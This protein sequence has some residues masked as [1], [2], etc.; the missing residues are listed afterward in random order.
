MQWN[1]MKPTNIKKGLLSFLLVIISSL[2]SFAQQTLWVGQSYTFDV[3][4]SVMGITANMSWSTSGGYLSLSGSG[5]YRNITVTQY[6][7]GTATVT[8]EWDYKLTSSG[9]YT[10]TK[11]QVTISCRDNQVSISPTS[12]TMS[13]GETRYVSYRHQYDNQYTSSANAYYQ[14]SDPSICTVSS[15]GE[16]IAKS[17][18][19]T[20]IN[21][22]SKISSVSPYCKVTVEN[23]KPTSISIPA[24]MTMTAGEQRTL[25]AN[26]I[27]SNAQTT[28]SWK[29]SNNDVATVNNSGTVIAKKHGYVQIAATT[30]N[31]L[32]STCGVT[33]NK[34]KLSLTSS[35]GSG[36]IQNNTAI[37]LLASE[38]NANIYYTIDGSMPT[39]SSTLYQTPILLSGN[40]KVKAFATHQDFVD[41]DVLELEFSI[42]SLSLVSTNPLQG[43]KD[44]SP[45]IIPCFNFSSSIKKGSSFDNIILS[46]EGETISHEAIIEGN[47]LFII[48]S[49]SLEHNSFVVEI[50][51]NAISTYSDESNTIITSFFDYA[52]NT[53]NLVDSWTSRSRLMD[54]GDLYIWG[55][56]ED[57]PNTSYGITSYQGIPI[58]VLS[59]IKKY[60]DS[61]YYITKDGILMGWGYNYNDYLASNPDNSILGDGTKIHRDNAVKISDNVERIETGWTSGLIKNDGTLW[62]WGQNRF[63][64]IGQGNSGTTNYALSPVKVL[65][66]VKDF[67]LGTWHSLALKNDGSVWAW[68]YNKAIGKSSS[69]YSPLKIIDS[70]VVEIMA[71]SCHNIVRKSNGDVYCFGENSYGEIGN[72]HTSTYETPY[73]VMSDA[74]K[75]FA[76]YGGCYAIKSNGDLYRWGIIGHRSDTGLYSPELV[77]SNVKEAYVTDDV[78]FVLLN[79]KT[80]WAMGDNYFGLL[81]LGYSEAN[82]CT[83]SFSK[84]FDDVE[85]VWPLYSKVFVK[86]TDGTYWGL[87]QSLSI[88]KGSSYGWAKSPVEVLNI[89][90]KNILSISLPDEIII[91]LESKGVAVLEVEPSNANYKQI[92][93]YSSDNTIAS[94]N[95]I[96]VITGTS[97]GETYI[98]AN[99]LDYNNSF[100]TSCLVKV[101]EIGAGVDEIATDI[102]NDTLRIFNINGMLIYQGSSNLIPN[103]YNGIYII[104]TNSKTIKF[105]KQ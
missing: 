37:Q 73:K 88:D 27:P 32:S 81:G 9:S 97:I 96:G 31:G 92:N 54:N 105:I 38:P 13:P 53:I 8:C 2:T 64:Q 85:T 90:S 103:L 86:K 67:S 36:L 11:R 42:T 19:T 84:V 70:D 50:P 95:E 33:V 6:F 24:T 51:E 75:V 29:S 7:S 44:S 40:C 77:I 93:W 48:P 87:G 23:V 1:S 4:S 79:D 80:V 65:S 94:I 30:D 49:I 82:M 52:T 59:D 104:K 22:Y 76:T 56:K 91:E 89:E 18:G 74:I 28:I 17:P 10:H 57:F 98:E 5:F 20:Y 58:K 26:I 34:S 68:G 72:G 55:Y 14:S 60:Y 62:L 100:S 39:S 35:H 69:A 12:L 78:V 46:H 15:S 25:T 99:V 61:H 102:D 41:S 43:T 21:V 3:T 63:G 47:K 16:V 101:V 83:T 45:Y 71:G 66:N